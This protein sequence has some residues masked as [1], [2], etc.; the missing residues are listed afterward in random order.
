MGR[1]R[2][3]S[4]TRRRNSGGTGKAPSEGKRL[5]SSCLTSDRHPDLKSGRLFE[6]ARAAFVR[7]GFGGHR[8]TI[9]AV[10]QPAS[11]QLYPCLLRA[12]RAPTNTPP[13]ADRLDACSGLLYPSFLLRDYHARSWSS[14]AEAA[15]HLIGCQ[16]RSLASRLSRSEIA[17]LRYS[18]VFR[19]W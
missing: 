17:L 8:V 10:R 9:L 2:A 4:A 16:V 19:R 7:A 13:P 6:I 5:L 3:T 18:Q 11:I 12:G 14:A 1:F 15:S